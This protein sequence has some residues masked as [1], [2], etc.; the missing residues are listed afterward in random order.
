MGKNRDGNR[1]I[2]EIREMEA[3]ALPIVSGGTEYEGRVEA[4]NGQGRSEALKS[5]QSK[6]F[7]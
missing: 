2:Y 4:G 1:E 5:E 3:K 7:I 6:H